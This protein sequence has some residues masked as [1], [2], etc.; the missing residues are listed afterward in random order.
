MKRAEK[1]PPGMVSD[2]AAEGAKSA[3][4]DALEEAGESKATERKEKRE[5]TEGTP[6]DAQMQRRGKKK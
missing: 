5:G 4:D 2:D 1:R 3:M 6:R